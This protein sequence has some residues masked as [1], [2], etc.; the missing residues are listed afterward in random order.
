M[1]GFLVEYSPNHKNGIGKHNFISLLNK[2]S[3]RGPDSQ[4]Y[5]SNN[6]NLQLG[7][8]RLAILELSEAGE[9]PMKS[10]DNRYIIVFNGEIYNHLELRKQ[11]DFSGFRG[12]SDTETIIACMVEW[13]VVKTIGK[14]NGMF[15]LV[16]Y[17]TLL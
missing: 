6:S 16:V 15:S 13:G 17:D 2:S 1:C 10:H 4:G 11:L 9:Q 7:F 5:F 12:L 8:N 3:V 14:L